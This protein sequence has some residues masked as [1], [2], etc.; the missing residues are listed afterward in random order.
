MRIN[1][2]YDDYNI[3]SNM[4]DKISYNPKN[5]FYKIGFVE[6]GLFQEVFRWSNSYN[7]QSYANYGLL[8]I[9]HNDIVFSCFENQ[10]VCNTCGGYNKPEAN[11]FVCLE[12]F[13]LYLKENEIDEKID[14]SCRGMDSHINNVKTVLEKITGRELFIVDCNG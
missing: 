2:S 7:K 8:Q 3:T 10:G 14:L 1:K 9:W 5:S 11:L 6:N 13:N 12:Q 4:Y